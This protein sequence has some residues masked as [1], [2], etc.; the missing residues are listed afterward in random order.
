[1]RSMKEAMPI[2]PGLDGWAYR[3]GH[4]DDRRV[5]HRHEELEM[6]LVVQG[7][8]TYLIGDRRCDVHADSQIWLFPTQNHVLVN[9]SV[10][11]QMW[12]VYYRPSL[13]SRLCITP[14]TEVLRSSAPGHVMSRHLDPAQ[15]ARISTLLLELESGIDDIPRYNAGIAYSLLLAW[16]EF[17]WAP[18]HVPGRDVHPAVERAAFLIRDQPDLRGIQELAR[19][20]G[21]SP[22]RLS[23]VF[24]VHMGVPLVHFWNR[25]RLERFLRL[26]GEGRR[27]TVTQ[28]ALDAGFGSYPQF[29]RV[30]RQHVGCGPAEYRRTGGELLPVLVDEAH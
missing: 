20:A 28:A 11:F 3:A 17:S 5:P 14:E 2:A 8:G 6:N 23:R 19:L 13:V 1:M 9:R 21:L 15:A 4:I 18:S 30:F 29:Y 10:D 16:H 24:R 7:H 27:L 12:V 22:S 26:Y 25:Q